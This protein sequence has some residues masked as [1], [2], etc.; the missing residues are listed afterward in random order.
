MYPSSPPVMKPLE[1]GNAQVADRGSP[2]EL[3][4]TV[5]NSPALS[6]SSKSP[7][8]QHTSILSSLNQAWQRKLCNFAGWTGIVLSPSFNCRNLKMPSPI[9]HTIDESVGL[10]EHSLIGEFWAFDTF[11]EAIG[12][13]LSHIQYISVQSW[14][15]LGEVPVCVSKNLL[16]DEKATQTNSGASHSGTAAVACNVLRFLVVT[17]SNTVTLA[18]SEHLSAT[19]RYRL[20]E[21]TAKH[22]MPS[23]PS[24]PWKNFCCFWSASHRIVLVPAGYMI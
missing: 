14:L 22:V 9:T 12:R 10:K 23:V 13:P 17:K 11:N 18:P 6:N 16:S 1:K 15:P 4:K 5:W 2:G 19:A 7:L 20:V 3:C 24:G 21:L 8:S